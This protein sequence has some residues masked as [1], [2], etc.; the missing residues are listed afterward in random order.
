MMPVRSWSAALNEV[1]GDGGR[2][3]DCM[4]GLIKSDDTDHKQTTTAAS[5]ALPSEDFRFIAFERGARSRT[6]DSAQLSGNRKGV[7]DPGLGIGEQMWS[8]GVMA[9]TPHS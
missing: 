3:L 8:W 1:P 2:L 4:H 5:L 6:F 9:R 7:T